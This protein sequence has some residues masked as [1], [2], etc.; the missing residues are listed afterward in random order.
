MRDLRRIRKHLD[1][2][3][4]TALANALI[5]SRL[6]YCNSLLYSVPKAH[7]DKL[8]CVQNALA[9]IITNSSR[10]TSASRLL[11]Q[12]HW[13]PVRSHIHFK[14]G[15]IT[16]KALHFDQPTSLKNL[17]SSYLTLKLKVNYLSKI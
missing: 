2:N 4:A 3:T 5:S 7:I 12:L 15:L 14:I 11:E 8:Q 13:L 9:R 1:N 10:Y 16:Y 6:D 17:I